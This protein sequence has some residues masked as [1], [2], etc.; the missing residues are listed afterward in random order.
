MPSG[1]F[2]RPSNKSVPVPIL[3]LCFRVQSAM[4]VPVPPGRVWT[5]ETYNAVMDTYRDY[6]S[7]AKRGF[8]FNDNHER[9]PVTWFQYPDEGRGSSLPGS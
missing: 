3:A 7:L 4:D 2:F 1:P 5:Q 6:S 8:G 9:T